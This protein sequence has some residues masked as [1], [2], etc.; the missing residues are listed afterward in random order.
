MFASGTW[1]ATF[2]LTGGGMSQGRCGPFA[3]GAPMKAVSR[4]VSVGW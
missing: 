3:G 4:G 1:Y 2:L